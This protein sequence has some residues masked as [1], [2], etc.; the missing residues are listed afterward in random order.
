MTIS[1][2]AK[3]SSEKD[4]DKFKFYVDNEAQLTLNYGYDDF[5][6]QKDWQK[7]TFTIPDGKHTLCF[8]YE[9][10][11][12]DSFG[13]DCAWIDDV[14]LSY[15]TDSVILSLEDVLLDNIEV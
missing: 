2:Y 6:Y 1:F 12:S 8:S 9:K 4:Y 7:Y 5:G 15:G 13:K 10:D 11:Q 14:T 3:V